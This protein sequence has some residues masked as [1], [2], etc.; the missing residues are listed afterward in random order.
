MPVKLRLGKPRRRTLYC[1]EQVLAD[2]K[3][4]NN[5]LDAEKCRY[6]SAEIHDV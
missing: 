6:F 3:L 4:R 5:L 2:A 1:T